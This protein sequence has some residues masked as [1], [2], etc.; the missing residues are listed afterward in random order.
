MIR[1]CTDSIGWA[2]TDDQKMYRFNRV[3]QTDDQKMY[4]F[5]RV[6]SD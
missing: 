3:A 6:G 4:R 1:K 2:Q 5:D